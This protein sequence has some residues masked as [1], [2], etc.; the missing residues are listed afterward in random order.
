MIG[1]TVLWLSLI[2]LPILLYI[3]LRNET[4]FK[5][6]IA[7]GVTLP[8]E[9]RQHPEVLARLEQ[10][11]KEELYV[12]IGLIL[13][14]IP[15]IF[16]NFSLS[17]TI[18][19]VWMTACVV[20]PYIPYILCNRDLKRIKVE[21]GW[22]Q[23][24]A[25]DT[26]TVDLGAIPEQKWL[27]PW[28]FVP[29]LVLSLLTLVFDRDFAIMYLIDAA[30]IIFFW[31]AYRY[32]F[33]N[34]AE[35]VDSNTTVTIALTRIRRNQW[36]K[37]WLL[38]AYSVALMN[39]LAYLTM[40]SP[41]AMTVGIVI[42]MVVLLGAS[43]HIEFQTRRL[44][45]TLTADSGKDFYVDDDDKWLGG[46]VYYN[47]NDSRIIINDRVG[48]NSSVNLAKPAG[49]L[50]YGILALLLVTLPLWGL[51]LGNSEIKTDIGTDSILIKGGM[52]EYNISVDDV[53][54]ARL[55]TELPA[56]T[57]VG[58]TG[59]P[60]FL[61]GDFASQEYGKLKVCLDPTSPPFVLVETEERTYL[62]GTK[63]E[64][65]TNAIYEAVK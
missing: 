13:L 50:M 31:V 37:M 62:I 6:N 28:A 47:P 11:K 36:G 44:Q 57:R 56:I 16:I 2:W 59:L 38:C 27:S 17:F 43:M 32:L 18:W 20:V 35:I 24:A 41:T 25:T 30:L 46:L 34:K 53:T 63:D 52:H 3:M 48:T 19:F 14:G 21:H 45:E 60:E 4:K 61:G 29:A 40:Y 58:G 26:V 39:W 42:F 8:F 9:G 15:G 12:C 33:R 55:L 64:A 65:L 54:D 23:P 7:V 51:L 49:K 5:K 10:F 1:N 22:K